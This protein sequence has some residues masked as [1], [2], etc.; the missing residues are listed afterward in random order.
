M[1]GRRAN[2]YKVKQHFSYTATELATCLGVHKNTVRNW[3]REGLEAID[4]SRPTLFQGATVRDFLSKRHARS[5]RPCPPGTL[6]CFRC[7]QP[8]RPLLGLVDYVP[9]RH[10]TG[11]LGAVC[12]SCQGTMHRRVREDDIPRIMRGCTVQHSQAPASLS[13][14]ADPSLNCGLNEKD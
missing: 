8:R 11:N 9:M 7:R 2:L 4:G 1:P 6:Y 10:G 13:G 5:K 14:K 12:E 3:Q